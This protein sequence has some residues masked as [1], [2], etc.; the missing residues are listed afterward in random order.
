M[1][2]LFDLRL[3]HFR[4][5]YLSAIIFNRARN[6][7]QYTCYS[8]KHAKVTSTKKRGSNAFDRC[9]LIEELDLVKA[10]HFYDTHKRRTQ[11]YSI[12][13]NL[14]LPLRRLNHCSTFA[15]YSFAVPA[16]FVGNIKGSRK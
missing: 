6:A 12:N 3:C 10:V 4:R 7:E 8:W 9:T 1:A 13:H 5:Q 2:A 14:M 16:S 11:R 15:A